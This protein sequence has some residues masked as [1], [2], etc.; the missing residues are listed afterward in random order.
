[1]DE[2]KK[3]QGKAHIHPISQMITEINRIFSEMGFEVADGPEL[4]TEFYNFDALNVPANHP[5]RDMWDTFWVKPK[6]DGRLMRTHT[7]PVQ[8]RYMEKH[9][10]PFAIIVPGKV[11]RYEATDATHEAQFHQAEGL[12]VGKDISL[13]NLKWVLAEF[14]EKFFGKKIDIRFRPSFFPFVEPG[15]E[16]DMSCFNCGV[17]KSENRCVRNGAPAG[18]DSKIASGCAL[19]KKTGWIEI[20]GAGMV[21]PKVLESAGVDSREF[22]GF[23]FGVGIDRLAMLKYGVDD[24]RLFYSGDLRLVNQF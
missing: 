1:M 3:Q 9:K 4:E 14:F 21:H 2:Q 5:A 18:A 11:F 13:A 16:I 20:M 12:M 17:G 19:C 7:S 23:A 22:S 15:V 10:P 24:V 8:I 6:S